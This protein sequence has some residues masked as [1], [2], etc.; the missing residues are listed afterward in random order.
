MAQGQIVKL[1][2]TECTSKFQTSAPAPAPAPAPVSAQNTT[3]TTSQAIGNN[4]QKADGKAQSSDAS[5]LS[6][7]STLLVTTILLL[8]TLL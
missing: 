4:T 6:Y 1:K 5:S 8:S 7:S 2:S 3:V